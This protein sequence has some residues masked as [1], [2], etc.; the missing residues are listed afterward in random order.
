VPSISA[1]VAAASRK[2]SERK[3]P[4]ARPMVL[5]NLNGSCTSCTALPANCGSAGSRRR[6]DARFTLAVWTL[7]FG[8]SAVWTLVPSDACHPRLWSL[9]A[10]VSAVR[11]GARTHSINRMIN[12]RRDCRF[13]MK[14][15]KAVVKSHPAILS[16]YRATPGTEGPTLLFNR[17]GA[18]QK[19]KGYECCQQTCD[20]GRAARV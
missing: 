15:G 7:A 14:Q 17:L 16:L 1:G 18:T 5:E 13:L 20:L 6:V 10:L 2:W 11:D 19:E 3:G 9:S 8:P 12:A 4:P